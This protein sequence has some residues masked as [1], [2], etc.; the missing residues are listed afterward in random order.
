MYAGGELIADYQHTGVNTITTIQHRNPTTGQWIKSAVRTELDPL[1]ADVGYI[2]PYLYNLTYS[3]IMGS[4]NLYDI[5]GNARDLR[6]GCALDGMSISCSFLNE[7]MASETGSIAL[8]YQLNNGRIVSEQG[9]IKHFGAGIF[10]FDHP[11]VVI[12][13]EPGEDMYRL[14]WRVGS[15]YLLPQ[16]PDYPPPRPWLHNEDDCHYLANTLDQ[17]A[18]NAWTTTG[19]VNALR[20]RFV[21]ESNQD[22]SA[23]REFRS[24]GFKSDFNDDSG[25]YNQVRH[26]IGG[27]SN[28]YFGG[29]AAAIAPTSVPDKLVLDYA[30]EEA[31]R[32]AN[33]REGPDEHADR[34]LNEVSAPLG[35]QLAFGKIGRRQLADLIRKEV[36]G[37]D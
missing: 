3:D 8:Q 36:C 33:L 10:L 9:S 32:R 26:F 31:V 16:N 22:S 14:S 18:K 27:F 6:G 25:S 30:I 21:P 12:D 34:D 20:D 23:M 1:G 2:S 35:V 19:F 37:D 13:N 15:F 24:T 17:Y 5:R 7:M 4:D 28:A 11:N 29:L